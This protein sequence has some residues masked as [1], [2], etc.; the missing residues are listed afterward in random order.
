MSLKS[1]YQIETSSFRDPSGFL[2]RRNEVLYRQVNHFYK[3]DY[4]CLMESGLY[5]ALLEAELLI[6]HEEIDV[7][8]IYPDKSYK[9]IKPELI[10]FISYPYE[11]TF[12]QLK[13]AALTTLEIQKIAL[14]FGMTLKD[15]TA[16]NIQFKNGKPI[17][18][19]SLSFEKYQ[20]GQIWKPYRQFCQH[21][22]A[23][24]SLMS[25]RDIRL[26]QLLRIYL[27]G[28]PLDL[29]S[30]L[31]P[32]K[33]RSMFSMLAHIHAHAKSQKHYEGKKIKVSNRKMSKN[34]FVGIIE[35]L[36]SGVKKLNW[37]PEGTEWGDYYSDTNYSDKAFEQ[38]KQIISSFLDKIHPREVWDLGANTGEFSRISS[39]K[40]IDTISFDI[41][42]AAVEKNYLEVIKKQEKY[43]LPLILDLTN[44]T[45]SIGWNNEE[46][47]SF[48]SRGPVDLILALALIHHLAISNN[49]PFYKIVEFL[50]KNCTSLIIEFI[51]KTD[52]QVQRLLATREDIFYDYDRENFEN[53]FKKKFTIVESSKLENSERI[54]YFMKKKQ[55][56]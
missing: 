35:S 49:L 28:I 40:S 29:A 11:W 14:K 19:D 52:S 26:N 25:H 42:P 10:R 27:D 22:F 53:E 51:P 4:D 34:S 43:L 46:R 36:Y 48:V 54:L 47:N 1:N 41:D 12:S 20:E 3:E 39:D 37:T 8:P 15:C 50:E 30:K 56:K 23:P 5:T 31:L 32:L 13:N 44:P 6:P 18:I 24:L 16:Y 17:L 45:P 21:F 55:M 38:K 2:F 9:V 7:Q 33:T